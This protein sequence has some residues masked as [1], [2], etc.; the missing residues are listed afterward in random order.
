VSDKA[1]TPDHDDA[2]LVE[3]AELFGEVVD[4]THKAVVER[5]ARRT[6]PPQATDGGKVLRLGSTSGRVEQLSP[7]GWERSGRPMEVVGV[8]AKQEGHRREVAMLIKQ[9][10]VRGK[11]VL[12]GQ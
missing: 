7:R 6:H 5:Q 8:L 12:I 2:E 10:R 1:H 3:I 11:C 4:L 9:S